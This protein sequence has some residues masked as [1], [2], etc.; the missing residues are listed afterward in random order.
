MSAK[1]S[2]FI[3]AKYIP[4]G[5][6]LNDPRAMKR[7]A[8]IQF[9]QHV[10]ARQESHGN[11][12]AFRFKA[13]LPSRKKGTLCDAKYC[14]ADAGLDQPAPAPAPRRKKKAPKATNDT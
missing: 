7:E 14:D 5:I 10:A 4:C 2:D 13:I 9:F 6:T 11:Q 1:Q 12:D 8:M 3:Q